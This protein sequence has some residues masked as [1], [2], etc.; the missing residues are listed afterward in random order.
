MD[1]IT[2]WTLPLARVDEGASVTELFGIAVGPFVLGIALFF[3][4]LLG[5]RAGAFLPWIKWLGVVPLI[6]GAVIGWDYFQKVS[7]PEGDAYVMLNMIDKKKFLYQM[8]FIAPIVGLVLLPVMNHFLFR[9]PRL[10]EDEF[11]D[12]EATAD[13]GFD[14][15]EH[16]ED[17]EEEYGDEHHEPMPE[18]EFVEEEIYEEEYVEEDLA[19][20]DDVLE[21]A[22]PDPDPRAGPA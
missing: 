21:E 9:K 5:Q 8:A 18:E 17:W 11:I 15:A 10:A 13:A 14:E 4:G 6:F 16:E 20:E 2:T 12:H 22:P 7:G 3:F 1:F 19:V